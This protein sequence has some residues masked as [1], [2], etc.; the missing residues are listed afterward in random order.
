MVS[1][2]EIEGQTILRQLLGQR[3]EYGGALCY[4]TGAMGGGKTSAM[5]SWMVYTLMYYPKQKIFF[6]ETYDAPLQS[7]KLKRENVKFFVKEDSGVVFRDLNRKLKITNLGEEKFSSFEELWEKAESGK[8]NT[9]F[10]GDRTIWME[11]IAYM[12]HKGEWVHVF[13]DEIGEVIPSNSSG[14]LHKR[15]GQFAIFAK[16]F[17]KCRMKVISNTQSVRDMDWRMLDK[18][19][20]RVFLPGAMADRQHSRV[21]QRAIDHLD[22]NEKKGNEA[23]I[24]RLGKFGLISFTNIF[25][26]DTDYIIEAHNSN[27]DE[28]I[29]IPQETTEKETK[30]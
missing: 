2:P 3:D 5:L 27:F 11:F 23:Y 20:Y 24:D 17:R 1:K 6:S 18:F 26:P 10:F 25:K 22:S 19:M 29:A 4:I 9:V 30:T 7:F 15:I 21:M 28:Y 14:R 12:R 8:I 13:I 16:D